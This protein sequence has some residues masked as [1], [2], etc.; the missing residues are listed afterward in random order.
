MSA[1]PRGALTAALALLLA[2]CAAE[3]PRLRPAAAEPVR[4]PPALA[5]RR[6]VEGA[7]PCAPPGHPDTTFN[8]CCAERACRG[9][10][11]RDERTEVTRCSCFEAEG[12]CGEG[13]VCCKSKGRCT[14]PEEC[15]LGRKIP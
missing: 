1:P 5:G 10:C 3:P 2:A 7:G 9:Y 4:L 6:V 8:A 15:A 12:G 13:Q 11:V 14:S